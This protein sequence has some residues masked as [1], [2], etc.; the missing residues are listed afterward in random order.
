MMDNVIFRKSVALSLPV[1]KVLLLFK[2]C[3]SQKLVPAK[4][5]NVE[6]EEVEVVPKQEV[7]VVASHACTFTSVVLEDLRKIVLVLKFILDLV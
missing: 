2:L 1:W 6:V 3:G 7:E 4:K 5:L